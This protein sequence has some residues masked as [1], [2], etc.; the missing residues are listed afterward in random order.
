MISKKIGTALLAIL[1]CSLVFAQQ[2]VNYR[3]T[4]I[5]SPLV[6]EDGTA[7][8]RLWAPLAQTVTIRGDW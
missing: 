3:P 2:N 7:T 1:I 6:N 8:F 4:N 5:V